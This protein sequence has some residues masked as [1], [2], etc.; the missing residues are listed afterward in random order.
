MV[1]TYEPVVPV[2]VE[3][4]LLTVDNAREVATWCR[5]SFFGHTLEVATRS[6][7]KHAVL[8][9][10]VIRNRIGEFSVMDVTAFKA[11]YKLAS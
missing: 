10:Y 8:G 3:A 1:Q 5:G 2:T 7:M 9:M 6:G 11:K 4:V